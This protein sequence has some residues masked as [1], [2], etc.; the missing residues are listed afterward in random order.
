MTA[1]LNVN[2]AVT[3]VPAVVLEAPGPAGAL[4]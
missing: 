2:A 3:G 1:E 4:T